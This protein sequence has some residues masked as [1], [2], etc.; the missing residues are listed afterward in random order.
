MSRTGSSISSTDGRRGP[1]AVLAAGVLLSLCLL[2]ACGFRPI[3]GERSQASAAALSQVDIALIPD[4]TGQMLRNELL[5]RFHPRGVATGDRFLLQ[6]TLNEALQDLAI[7]KNEVATRANLTLTALF[8]VAR[9]QDGQPVF[10]GSA[11]S[12]NSYNILTSDFATLSA[13]ADAR[14]RAVRQL[15]DDIKERMSVWLIQTGGAPVR[16]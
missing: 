1:R 9:S 3:H 6:V 5:Q 16:R 12:V 2:S 7:K 10:T 11:S 15:A 4:R 8:T 14:E 13:R